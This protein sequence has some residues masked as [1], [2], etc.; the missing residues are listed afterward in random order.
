[1]WRRGLQ[2]SSSGRPEGL[3]PQAALLQKGMMGNSRWVGGLSMAAEGVKALT[4]SP[5]QAG[6]P[7]G[8]DRP[9]HSLEQG[10]AII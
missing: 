10:W 8:L 6:Q 4:L 7:P 3:I 9:A 2:V 1:M 5:P